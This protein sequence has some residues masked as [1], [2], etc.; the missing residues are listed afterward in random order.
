MDRLPDVLHGRLEQI[1]YPHIRARLQELRDDPRALLE[2]VN[3]L[4]LDTRDGQRRGFDLTCASALMAI[5]H[6]LMVQLGEM[7]RLGRVP[8]LREPEF[9]IAGDPPASGYT[10]APLPKHW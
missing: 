6:D 2:Y 7:E 1:A 8:P 4:F 9:R 5:R 3:H 10:P